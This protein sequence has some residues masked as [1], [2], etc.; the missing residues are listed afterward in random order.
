MTSSR[1]FVTFIPLMGKSRLTRKVDIAANTV[2]NDIFQCKSV[3]YRTCP[4][5]I[6]FSV[7]LIKKLCL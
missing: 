6:H 2:N 7:V 4:M 1:I 5:Q 3:I